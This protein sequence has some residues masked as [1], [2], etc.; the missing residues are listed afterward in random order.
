MTKKDESEKPRIKHLSWLSRIELTDEE[1]R[2]F[3]GQLENILDL[4]KQ[5]DKVPLAGVQPTYH[6]LE[7]T[8]VWRPDKIMPSASEEILKNSPQMKG[9]YVKSPRMG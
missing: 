3:S 6:A 4:F 7:L 9:R 2:L 8:N 1:E 5:I